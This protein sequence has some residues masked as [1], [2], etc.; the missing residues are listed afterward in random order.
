MELC[1][2]RTIILAVQ[3]SLWLSQN[4]T[5]HSVQL[6]HLPQVAGNCSHV[7][8]ARDRTPMPEWKEWAEQSWEGREQG[9]READAGKGAVSVTVSLPISYPPPQS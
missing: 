7:P 6:T 9:G 8:V 4:A 3:G 2:A 1:T 5:H